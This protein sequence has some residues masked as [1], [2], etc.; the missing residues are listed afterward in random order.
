MNI[1]K[2]I[3][4]LKDK[5]NKAKAFFERQD[6]EKYEDHGKEIQGQLREAWARAVE[7]ILLNQVIVRFDRPIQTHRLKVIHD[8]TEDDIKEIDD[9][10]KKASTFLRGHDQPFAINEPIPDPEEIK[11][12]IEKLESWVSNMR[13]RGR[14]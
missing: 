3:G 4:Y 13:K 7:E 11:K 2:R 1:K 10:M 9:G 5:L 14:S 8:I 6:S 12:D